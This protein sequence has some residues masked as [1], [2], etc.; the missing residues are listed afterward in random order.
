[1]SE[2]L[3]KYERLKEKVDRLQGEVNALTKRMDTH[4]ETHKLLMRDLNRNF[5]KVDDTLKD[6]LTVLKERLPEKK[7]D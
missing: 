4:D 1:M 3:N 6:I 5:D 7:E 2:E